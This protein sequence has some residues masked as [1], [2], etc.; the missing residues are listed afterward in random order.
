[1]ATSEEPVPVEKVEST[2][3]GVAF[4]PD[5]PGEMTYP[6]L[7]VSLTVTAISDSGL[8][9]APNMPNEGKVKAPEGPV[10]MGELVLWSRI[11][12]MLAAAALPGSAR[13]AL[14]VMSSM[15]TPVTLLLMERAATG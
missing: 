6:V 13:M 10:L 12:K 15:A 7:L 8:N 11:L 14:E 9:A 1:M 3:G 2:A 4:K 5:C